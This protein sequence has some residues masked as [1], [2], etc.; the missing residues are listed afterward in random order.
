MADRQPIETKNLDINGYAPLPWSRPHDLFA[1]GIFFGRPAFLGTT[2]P[3]GRPHAAGIGTLWHPREGHAVIDHQEER[4][5]GDWRER[6][7]RHV[8]GAGIAGRRE[9]C[10]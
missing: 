6:L 7:D 2:Q 5:L 4:N 3:D 9:R 10:D 1:A 8:S